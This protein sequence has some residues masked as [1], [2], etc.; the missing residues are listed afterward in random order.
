MSINYKI[1][2]MKFNKNIS[3]I[4]LLAIGIFSVH[5]CV[6]L[7]ED[8]SSVLS[9]ESLS[10]TADVNAALAPIYR[11]YQDLVKVPHEQGV[12]T[13]GSDDMTTWWAGN[14]AP[15]RVFDRFDFG[16]GENSDIN[17]LPEPWNAY[18]KTIYFANSLIDGL[19]TATAPQDVVTIA[20]GE[21]RFL[22][23]LSYYNLV[24]G[25]GNMPIILDGDVPTGEE[26]RA[27]VLANYQSIEAD[28]MIAESSLP[29]P[30]AVSTPGNASSGAAKALLADLYMTWAGWPV[31]DES[32]YALAKSK[33]KEV[34]D[35]NYYKL[36]PINNYWT[37]ENQNSL[38]SVFSLQFSAVEDIRSAYPAD[39]SF[40]EA[41]GWS[42]MYPERQFFLDFPEGPRK[43]ATFH[44]MIPQ[45]GV[46]GGVIVDKNPAFLPW[47]DSQRKHPMYKKHTEGEDLTLG[48]RTAGYRAVEAIRYAEVV[49]IYSE[50]DARTNG[51]NATSSG[52]EALNQV[53][54]RA[55]GVDPLAADTNI[56]VLTATVEEIVAEKG[57]E[58]AGEFKRWWDLVRTESVAQANSRRDPTEEVSLAISPEEINWKHYI[59]PI[60]FKAISTSNLIQNPEGFVIQ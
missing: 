11:T 56:D 60:P 49:L 21:A 47:Q 34:I 2:V 46:S 7:E 59:A 55:M 36:L 6:D 3:K 52:L 13:Y 50:A 29:A 8:V 33:A 37:L 51:G 57:W 10:G 5:S 17:W 4:F 25:Y 42:D 38:G 40:H 35:M 16:N 15:L 1:K 24:R 22:R 58:L 30:G 31:K 28:L 39:N 41:R 12:M 32:K 18:W 54:R 27:T 19:K 20:D 43:D 14:K 53:K 45:R 9:L 26:S 23:A 44:T 48:G